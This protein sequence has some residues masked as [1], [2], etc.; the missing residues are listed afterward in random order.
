MLAWSSDRV[1]NREHAGRGRRSGN[2]SMEKSTEAKMVA[3]EKALQMAIQ[4]Q[5]STQEIVDRA[6]VFAGFLTA[7]LEQSQPPE[8]KVIGFRQA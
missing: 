2:V 1:T 3:Y 6:K 7:P 4:P 5:L 8:P